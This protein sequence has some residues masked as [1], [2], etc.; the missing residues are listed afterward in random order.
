VGG[1]AS[2]TAA[3]E[4]AAELQA[5]TARFFAMTGFV[6]MGSMEFK[7]DATTDTFYLVE[8]TVARTD[9][10]EE[11]A[12]LNGVNLPLAA[13]RAETGLGDID[14]QATPRPQV[15][16]EST[17]DRWSAQMQHHRCGRGPFD[18]GPRTDAW[19]RWYDPMPW[20]SLTNRRLV[21]TVRRR[22]QVGRLGMLKGEGA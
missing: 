5:E 19:R 21:K 3:P 12:T 6:G 7:R 20:L 16:C 18:S 1:T 17:T 14:F 13:Y 4:A 22:L 15:W 10:Q 8:P 2:C 9:Y 11:V